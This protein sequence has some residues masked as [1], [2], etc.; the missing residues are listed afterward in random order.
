[1]SFSPTIFKEEI[2]QFRAR[3]KLSIRVLSI[4]M[5]SRIEGLTESQAR[6]YLEGRVPRTAPMRAA[7]IKFLDLNH[8]RIY[9]CAV[10]LGSMPSIQVA[11]N[12]Y[13]QH[14]RF[15]DLQDVVGLAVLAMLRTLRHHNILTDA[16]CVD[17]AWRLQC[18]PEVPAFPYQLQIRAGQILTIALVCPKLGSEV[19][20]VANLGETTTLYILEYMQK[21]QKTLEKL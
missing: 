19:L 13:L 20:L 3:K 14:E 18:S 6:H 16:I 8:V 2:K 12:D 9:G 17:G 5:S 4:E 7:I 11:Y 1:M 21:L 15:V 10:L